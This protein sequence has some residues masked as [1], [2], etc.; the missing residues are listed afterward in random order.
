MYVLNVMWNG[1]ARCQWKLEGNGLDPI[2]FDGAPPVRRHRPYLAFRPALG[3]LIYPRRFGP[4]DV[5]IT[6]A[7]RPCFV[8]TFGG[9]W[10]ESKA[11]GPVVVQR[12]TCYAAFGAAFPLDL[13]LLKGVLPAQTPS[14]PL[15]IQAGSC[16][17]NRE[18][19]APTFTR[20]G[21][22]PDLPMQPRTACSL[23]T[24]TSSESRSGG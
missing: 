11:L 24:A 6:L 13:C 14:M 21:S 23:K 5:R 19:P 3:H 12:A 2:C 7:D 22:W 17:C 9:A 1:N 10:L 4:G 20:L 16:P 15:A 8:S 18:P